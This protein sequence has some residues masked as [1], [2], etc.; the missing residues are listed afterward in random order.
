MGELRFTDMGRNLLVA[1]TEPNMFL[2]NP[3]ETALTSIRNPNQQQ[4]YSAKANLND[5]FGVTGIY[6]DNLVT[7]EE[8]KLHLQLKQRPN[9]VNSEP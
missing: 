5:I 3:F 8:Y 4:H 1:S 2:K 9:T 7:N 6:T